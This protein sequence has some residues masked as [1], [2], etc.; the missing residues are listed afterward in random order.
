MQKKTVSILLLVSIIAGVAAAFILL[1]KKKVDYTD[2]SYTWYVDYNEKSDDVF[3]VPGTRIH[4]IKNDVHKLVAALNGS[5]ADP[6]SFRTPA[7]REG[8]GAPK[9]KLMKVEHGVAFVEIINAEQVTQR[10]GS[11]GAQDYLA[12][13]T[14]S[15]TE[16][17]QIKKVNFIFEE[18]DHAVPGIYTRESFANYKIVTKGN[19]ER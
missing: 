6:G 4:E 8:A 14:Y 9:I 1:G 17:R 18:G 19:R 15:L 3:M 13:V 7:E 2:R 12:S 5:D 16:N 10:M 11:S